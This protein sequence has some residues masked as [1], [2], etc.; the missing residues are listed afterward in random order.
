[1]SVSRKI[2]CYVYGLIAVLALVGTWANNVPYLHLGF[3]KFQWAF[4][5]S[6]LANPASRSITVDIGFFGLV[7]F[8]WMIL[9]SRRLGLRG[10]WLYPAL[11]MF[12]G[13]SVFVPIFL[14]NRERA[15]AAR[16]NGQVAG[17]MTRFD[18]VGLILGGA[19]IVAYTVISVLQEG[20]P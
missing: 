8:I 18:V 5:T 11:F 20:K 6:T 9:E 17:T 13:T 14:I 2:L 12:V 15:L 16:D 10:V 4:W 7:V 19:V 1:M 3:L